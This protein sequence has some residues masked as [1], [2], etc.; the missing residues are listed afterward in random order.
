MHGKR[1]GPG[2]WAAALLGGGVVLALEWIEILVPP[3]KYLT[4]SEHHTITQ[5]FIEAAKINNKVYDIPG[6]GIIFLLTIVAVT[7]LI[8]LQ[9]RKFVIYHEL[10]NKGITIIDM[11]LELY[12]IEDGISKSKLV[13]SQRFHVNKPD[14]TAYHLN[15]KVT[16]E[17]GKIDL[18]KIYLDSSIGGDAVTSELVKNVTSRSIDIIERFES[19]LPR[20]HI[21]KY[22][23]AS[24]KK[25]ISPGG[26]LSGKI[27]QRRGVI[28]HTGEFDGPSP[29][30]SVTSTRNPVYN[31]SIMISFPT[32]LAPEKSKISAYEIRE[33]VVT[34][35]PVKKVIG[36]P[37]GSICYIARIKKIHASEFRVQWT[38][39]IMA[40][41]RNS[42]SSNQND[43][44]LLTPSPIP[45]VG[46]NASV[47]KG[48]IGKYTGFAIAIFKRK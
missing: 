10:T 43:G 12:F 9:L 5:L 15:H 24:F 14:V 28:Y 13:R 40:E 2:A 44:L 11:S 25:S 27:V 19:P 33:N 34:D 23:P 41:I 3:A 21:L 22:I 46:G 29:L 36:E 8:I 32:N 18:D 37:N 17:H 6:L 47:I 1:T 39:A 38:N 30:L 26:F 16:S 20:S 31:I 42:S 48:M 45:D 7:W 4:S 35:V